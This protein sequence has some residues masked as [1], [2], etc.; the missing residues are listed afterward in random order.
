[1]LTAHLAV[2]LRGGSC[3]GE[4]EYRKGDSG[5]NTDDDCTFQ[6][7]ENTDDCTLADKDVRAEKKVDLTTGGAKYNVLVAL[8]CFGRGWGEN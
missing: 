1:M 7:G 3:T 2:L 5:E 6:N 4:E 8:F